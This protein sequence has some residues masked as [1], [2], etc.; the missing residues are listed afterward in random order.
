[1]AAR[2]ADESV[3]LSATYD[4]SATRKTKTENE[5]Q[6]VG[7]MSEHHPSNRSPVAL[8]AS[9]TCAQ[10][11]K[12]RQWTNG[13]EA[14]DQK[15]LVSLSVDENATSSRCLAPRPIGACKARAPTG[16]PRPWPVSGRSAL[17]LPCL[18]ARSNSDGQPI[19]TATKCLARDCR[20]RTRQATG[21][22]TCVR[23]CSASARAMESDRARRHRAHH[24][25]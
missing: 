15:V 21:G 19:S 11:G 6:R 16:P 4:D 17:R 7:P 1:M 18:V 24:S 3:S 12:G 14:L 25:G 5:G 2:W 8:A 23:L 9:C 10:H 20:H 13:V 22:A